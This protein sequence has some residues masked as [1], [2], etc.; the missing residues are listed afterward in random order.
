MGFFIFSNGNKIAYGIK[1]YVADT[2]DDLNHIPRL[3]AGS[4]VYVVSESKFYVANSKGQWIEQKN[5]SGS[6][7]IDEEAVNSLIDEKLTTLE[8][9]P[10]PSELTNN[11]MIKTLGGQWV[12]A[13]IPDTTVTIDSVLNEESYN[14]IANSAVKAALDLKIE[15]NDMNTAIQSAITNAFAD[16]TE[17]SY[18]ICGVGEYN[19]STLEPDFTNINWPDPN[20]PTHPNKQSIYLVPDTDNY[21]EFIWIDTNNYDLIGTTEIDLSN[22]YDINDID[23][24]LALKAD[25]TDLNDL[26][27]LNDVQNAGYLTSVSW[28]DIGNKPV[29]FTPATHTHTY[30]DI[31][32]PPDLS[33]FLTATSLASYNYATTTD[34]STAVST[35]TAGLTGAMHYRGITSSTITNGGSE[36]V[37]IGTSTLAATEG[38]VVVKDNTGSGDVSGSNLEFVWDGSHWRQLGDENSYALKSRLITDTNDLTTRAFTLSKPLTATGGDAATNGKIILD[39]THSGQITNNGTKTLFGFTSNYAANAHADLLVGTT[40][41]YLKLRG[42][43]DRP[44]YTKNGTDWSYI[45]LTSDIKTPIASTSISSSSTDSQYASAKAVYDTRDKIIKGVSQSYT[46]KVESSWSGSAPANQITIIA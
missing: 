20:N 16:I 43:E 25:S 24:L 3:A 40:D 18:Y 7:D 8:T 46:I 12:I 30:S 41:Y 33:G 22:Y 39:E 44:K 9:L 45:A 19:I 36:T 21:R 10:D 15:E 42:Y 31:T 11:K 27:T 32:D 35:A 38:D 28:S 37:T 29:N 2:L 14:P 34:V 1:N 26:I 4:M 17:F 6:S 13:D 5:E 23:G